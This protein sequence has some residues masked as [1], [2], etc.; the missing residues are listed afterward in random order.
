MNPADLDPT[1]DPLLLALDMGY[2]HLRAGWALAEAFDVPVLRIDAPPIGLPY[3]V[4][5]WDR[6]RHVYELCSQLY[7]HRY[8]GM[9]PRRFLDGLTSIRPRRPRRVNP[10]STRAVRFHA[11]L[12]RHGLAGEV[13]RRMR[14]D[15]V[16]MVTTFYTPGLAADREGLDG[17]YV[18]VTDADAHR[19]WAP[20]DPRRTRI[21]YLAPSDRVVAR[22][23]SYGVPP[24]RIRL[25]G[26]PLP[27]S[28]VGDE[29]ADVLR[30]NLGRR[31]VRLRANAALREEVARAGE[32]ALP[33]SQNGAPAH[34]LLAIGGAGAQTEIVHKMLKELKELVKADRLRLTLVAGLRALVAL[35]FKHD[36]KRAGLDG[37]P[38]VRILAEGSFEEYWHAFNEALA[39]VDVIWT[40]PSEMVFYAA[41]GI[42]LVL[43]PHLGEH[44]R[45]NPEWVRAA[46]AAVPQGPPAEAGTWL[47]PLLESGRLADA[48]YRGWRNLPQQGTRE[49]QRIVTGSA[50]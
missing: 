23:T 46:G 3:D 37:H 26:F 16:R 11:K 24:E 8:L 5:V 15:G 49:I 35:R 18:V 22:L 13:V 9:L 1:P 30:R 48:A 44:E 32:V 19:V 39:E 36:V 47:P 50:T 4:R 40:K 12:L 34:L 21:T 17:A 38:G 6:S 25:T 31:L 14:E 43:A 27:L 42:P 29:T 33:E 28:L 7:G 10:A 45:Y 2:G 20:A 41:L